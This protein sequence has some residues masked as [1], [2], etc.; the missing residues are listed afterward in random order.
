MN[1]KQLHFFWTF[2][3]AFFLCV[4]Q[5]IQAKSID[6]STVFLSATP[7]RVHS[8]GSAT[9]SWNVFNGSNCLASG[10]WS[11]IKVN[12]GKE[13]ISNITNNAVYTLTCTSDQG[14]DISY[15][16]RVYVTSNPIVPY[17][18]DGDMSYP[19][20]LEGMPNVEN[21]KAPR[22]AMAEGPVLS[23]GTEAYTKYDAIAS[24][25]WQKSQVAA[26]QALHPNLLYFYH[27]APEEYQ[28]N[29]MPFTSSGPAT[30]WVSKWHWRYLSQV[31]GFIT[32]EQHWHP[33]QFFWNYRLCRQCFEL[34]SWSICCYI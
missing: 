28:L 17:I 6:E 25:V 13:I 4:D 1:T 10:D 2:S 33:P 14:G 7:A 5:N 29:N 11:G 12:E 16:T 24:H 27:V 9:L 32:Q 34:L 21:F 22:I 19:S 31:I 26:V 8:G 15:N 3:I 20:L 23:K 30:V 18:E